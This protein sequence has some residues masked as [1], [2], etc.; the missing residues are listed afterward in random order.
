M[1]LDEE[2]IMR[3]AD[4][5]Y[6][7]AKLPADTLDYMAPEGRPRIQSD[8]VKMLLRALVEAINSHEPAVEKAGGL[9]DDRLG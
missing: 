1:K 4:E 2:A 8:Q 6:A 7:Q 3:R 9:Y 5:L